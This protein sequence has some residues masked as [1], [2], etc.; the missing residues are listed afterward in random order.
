MLAT[1]T[2]NFAFL[3]V[4]LS[5]ARR[6]TIQPGSDLAAACANAHP[7][8]AL[9]CWRPNLSNCKLSG[10]NG[11]NNNN[12]NNDRTDTLDLQVSYKPFCN[13]L[14]GRLKG[15][16]RLFI[17]SEQLVVA[18]ALASSSQLLAPTWLRAP[19]C[20]YGPVAQPALGACYWCV[21]DKL[22]PTEQLHPVRPPASWQ[23][24]SGKLALVAPGQV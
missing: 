21:Q 2:N 18:A 17:G 5:L 16:F 1:H 15:G 7:V 10:E 4:A 9:L 6:H 23:A 11:N 24:S 3:T 20:S 13:G 8:N 14:Q 22:V 19:S 12:N